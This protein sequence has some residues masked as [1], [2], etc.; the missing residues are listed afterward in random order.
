MPDPIEQIEILCGRVV[1]RNIARI[2]E[3]V[4]GDLRKF[5]DTIAANRAARIAILTGFYIPQGQPAAAET[6]G[7]S[8]AVLM[9][10]GLKRAGYQA[11]VAT[12]L[13][14]YP[15][16]KAAAD[17]SPESVEVL[18]CG[19]DDAS[20]MDLWRRLQAWGVT[21]VVIIERAGL[22]IDGRPYDM[23]GNPLDEFTAKF[24]LIV[25][26]AHKSGVISLGVGDGGNEIGMGKI[27][28]RMIAEDIENG[29]KIACV[30]ATQYAMVC[31]V[32]NW[33]GVALLAAL[34]ILDPERGAKYLS[35]TDPA[36]ERSVLEH[37][38]YLGPAIDDIGDPRTR[39]GRKVLWIDDVPLDQHLALSAQLRA[40][41]EGAS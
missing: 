23:M 30:T 29:S 16:L 7:L 34:A 32:S 6:D 19:V 33:A 21:H 28:K 2:R 9:A 38:V 4:R 13:P 12:D 37:A 14:C 41:A 25:D 26:E 1:R 36:I 39:P 18:R 40:L 20:V 8:G 17:G 10:T 5:A 22:G 15:A 27:D 24:D 31:G 11:L 35:C 3:L